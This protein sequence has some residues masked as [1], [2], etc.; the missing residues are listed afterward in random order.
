MPA[1]KSGLGRGLG[2]LIPGGGG[3]DEVDIDLITPNPEQPRQRMDP[4]A[5]GELSA[6]IREHGL[7]QPLVVTRQTSQTGAVTYQL[8]AGERRL[9]AARTAGLARVPVV[10]R[11]TSARGML[12]L[13]LVENVQRADL[14]PLE[15]ATA[16]RRLVD[17]FGLSQADVAERVGKSRVAVSNT[18]RLLELPPAIK[19]GLAAGEITEGHARALLGAPQEGVRLNLYREVVSKS[20]SV[21]QTEELVRRLREG[22]P[23]LEVPDEEPRPRRGRPPRPVDPNLSAIEERLRASL[24]TQV[25]LERSRTGGR[26]VIQ[27]YGDEDLEGLITRLL[28]DEQA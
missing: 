24:N 8:I 22:S 3:V 17:E 9:H 18:L 6:S 15:E 27:F 19:D 7:L 12:E 13:A 26:I 28:G 11:E 16:Y 1:N 21:R 25:R 10:V 5:L 14:G 2:A 4:E 23:W 20:L